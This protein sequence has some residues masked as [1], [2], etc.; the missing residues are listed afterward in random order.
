MLLPTATDI[1][2]TDQLL[3]Q[4]VVGSE[5]F[6]T[7]GSL[8]QMQ[9]RKRKRHICLRKDATLNINRAVLLLSN[10]Q[11]MTGWNSE[12]FPFSHGGTEINGAGP[13]FEV[14]PHTA[15]RNEINSQTH[16]TRTETTVENID[17]TRHSSSVHR[18]LRGKK[19]KK[20][21]RTRE[22]CSSFVSTSPTLSQFL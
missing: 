6:K 1:Y 8:K 7:G 22:F 10:R 20:N 18:E 11:Q 19:T 2:M 21:M 15:R 17:S 16:P 12:A 13:L 3:C 14:R 4:E 5:N 9:M